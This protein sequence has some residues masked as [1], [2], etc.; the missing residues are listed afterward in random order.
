[1][2][3]KEIAERL[4]SLVQLDIDAVHAYGQAIEHIDVPNVREQVVAFQGDHERHINDL[5]SVV[6]NLGE[7]P[8]ELTKDFK[9]FLLKAFTSIRSMTGTE[10][11]LKALKS[12]EELTNKK[13]SE[14]RTWDLPV[15]ILSIVQRNYEDEQRHLHYV[16][17][18]ITDRVWETEAAKK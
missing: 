12:G 7:A 6:R 9:G 11:A 3:N 8:P 14:A 13:Y 1:M 5:S 17:Q 15:N 18:A 2:N 16:N 4:K 10:G